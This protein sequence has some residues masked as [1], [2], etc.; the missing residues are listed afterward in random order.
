MLDDLHHQ[1]IRELFPMRSH[2]KLQSARQAPFFWENPA[3]AATG[4]AEAFGS[5]CFPV[6][7]AVPKTAATTTANTFEVILDA[8]TVRLPSRSG[9]TR[10]EIGSHT[11]YALKPRSVLLDRGFSSR[12]SRTTRSRFSW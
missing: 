10:I 2:A 3:R 5:A 6:A 4:K 7:G 8:R 12:A 11:T 1:H 9:R